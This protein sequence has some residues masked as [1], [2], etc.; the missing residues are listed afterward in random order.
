MK[1]GRVYLLIFTFAC[2]VALLECSALITRHESSRVRIRNLLPKSFA[3]VRINS[4]KEKELRVGFD[5]TIAIET[6]QQ[7]EN[8]PDYSISVRQVTDGKRLV[9]SVLQNGAIKECD[10]TKDLAQIKEFVN[11]FIESSDFNQGEIGDVVTAYNNEHNVNDVNV[12]LANKYFSFRDVPTVFTEFLDIRS[13]RQ[14]CREFSK[15]AKARARKEAK[16]LKHGEYHDSLDAKTKI[17][18]D[19]IKARQKELA[20][21]NGIPLEGD[22]SLKL[23]KKR[24]RS[25]RATFDFN[26]VLIFPGTKWCGKGDLATCFEDLGDDKE[27]DVCCRDHDC[28][29]YV[30]PPFSS[31]FGVFN[32]RFHSLL[33]CECDQR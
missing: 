5:R 11:N 24:S 32:Y 13:Q 18:M 20:S 30:I 23:I 31:K 27:L 29:P 17:F 12:T 28:C 8:V 10:F 4:H 6:S 15:M 22:N 3:N 1:A 21:I 19:A 2:T 14:R 25:K 16:L 9:Q 33:H 26:S 7:N